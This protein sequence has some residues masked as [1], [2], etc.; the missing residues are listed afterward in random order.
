M[1]RNLFVSADTERSDCV[2][3]LTMSTKSS[4]DYLA[5]YRGLATQLFQHFRR[6]CQSIAR[7]THGDVE[8]KF[9][10]FDIPHGIRPFFVGGRVSLH[11][12]R[13]VPT[14]N[15][16]GISIDRILCKESRKL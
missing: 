9:L 10:D 2:T 4:I 12:V 6:S 8:D 1:H 11:P 15:T 13:K 14:A 5:V 3:C 7:F 16:I